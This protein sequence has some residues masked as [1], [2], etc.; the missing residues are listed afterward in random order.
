VLIL[1]LW[2]NPSI[3]AKKEQ[4]LS[5]GASIN[6]I[7]ATL[8]PGRF[9]VSNDGK[10]VVYVEKISRDKKQ[11]HNLFIADQV[12][13]VTPESSSPWVVLSAARG[14]QEKEKGTH[15]HFI[16]AADGYRYE[17]V[18]GENEY[19][20]IQFKK[21]SVRAPEMTI[22]NKQEAREAIPTLTLF[23][24][25]SLPEHAAELQWRLSIPLSTFLLGLLGV[26][27]GQV[28][29]RQGRY[30]TLLVAILIYIVYMNLLFAGR[31]LIEQGA[32]PISIGMWWVHLLILGVVGVLFAD[33]RKRGS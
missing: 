3:A 33:W 1:T 6:N 31:N 30:S 14:Y 9:Q 8:M 15:D 24:T 32:V 23:R 5:Q 2:I 18:P 22:T 12:E 10:R 13:T 27:L 19:K 28:K 4:L 21:Y 26:R 29:P 11:A 16:V 20:I 17:G 7:L 25:Y